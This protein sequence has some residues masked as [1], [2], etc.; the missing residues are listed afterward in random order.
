MDGQAGDV[1]VPPPDGQDGD[2]E[3]PNVKELIPEEA[4]TV[5]VQHKVKV[6]PRSD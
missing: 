4:T 5:L 6:D 2:E 3:I 1:P